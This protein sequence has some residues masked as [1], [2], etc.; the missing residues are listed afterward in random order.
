MA[1]KHLHD[2]I[3]AVLPTLASIQRLYVPA[4]FLCCIFFFMGCAFIPL[5]GIQNDEAL[6]ASGIYQ[7]VDV[8]YSVKILGIN[9]PLMIMTYVG[10]L[11]SWLYTPVFQLWLP[12]AYS[13]RLPVLLIGAFTVWLFFVTARKLLGDRAAL[14]GTVLLATDPMFLLATCFD[15]GPVAL[16]HFL[17]LAGL[18]LIVM[19]AQSQS[20]AQLA[21][22]FFSFGLGMWDKAL[23][24]WPLVGL[25]VASI[26]VFPRDSLRVVTFKRSIVAVASFCLGALPLLVYNVAHPFETF[27]GN[28]QYSTELFYGK[29]LVLRAT[30]QGR[31]LFG[32][33]T[34]VE[35][36]PHPPA[37]ANVIQNT[38]AW[39]AS[40]LRHPLHTAFWSAFIAALLIV[41]VLWFGRGNGANPATRKVSVF[42]IVVMAVIWAQMAFTYNAG[43]GV[44]HT[45]LLWPF[46]QFLIG[47]VYAGISCKFRRYAAPIL[48]AAVIVVAFSNLLVV[49]EHYVQLIENGTSVIWSDA[50]YPLSQSMNK[51]PARYVATIDWGML[52]TLRLLDRG[53]LSLLDEEGALANK[54]ELSAEDKAVLSILLAEPT[55]LFV[56]HIP[57]KEI[58]AGMAARLE[59][60]AGNRKFTKEMLDVV[61]DRNGREVFQIFRFRSPDRSLTVK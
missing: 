58:Y 28:A 19:Y 51:F 15:W 1:S 26:I 6:F 54:P 24:A 5:T 50:L 60:F 22:A 38:C 57:G 39:L 36:G 4:I 18:L 29:F 33:M 14:I 17:L 46:P 35:P 32:W 27:R 13:V 52:N 56:G 45:I 20:P 2:A 47:S 44:H 10:A 43:G 7:P 21:L 48:T 59:D 61:H 8:Q 30:F 41:P 40:L 23:F 9:L 25:A 31:A 12:S 49:N 37:A 3:P 55:T 42:A 16:Q 53:R 34:A 11:K